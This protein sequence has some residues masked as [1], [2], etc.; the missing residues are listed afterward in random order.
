MARRRSRFAFA[1]GLLADPGNAQPSLPFVTETLLG[2]EIRDD[3]GFD[4]LLEM[5][6]L[7]LCD[8]SITRDRNCRLTFG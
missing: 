4:A 1:F 8:F 3:A 2:F 6:V 7:R 5:D